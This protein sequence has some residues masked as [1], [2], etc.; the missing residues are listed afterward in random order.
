MIRDD[1][2]EDSE[3]AVRLLGLLGPSGATEILKLPA[4]QNARETFHLSVCLSVCLSVSLSVCL[5]DCLFIP[6]SGLFCGG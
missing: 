3:G 4:V 5:S 1:I 6:F 2:Y